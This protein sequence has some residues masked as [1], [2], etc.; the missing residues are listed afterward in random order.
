MSDI[1][2][3]PVPPPP[4]RPLVP[5]PE[6]APFPPTPPVYAP[7]PSAAVAVQ[8]S[9]PKVVGII[10]IVVAALGIMG[11]V[12]GVITWAGMAAFQTNMQSTGQSVQ[13]AMPFITEMGRWKAYTVLAGLVGAGLQIVLLVAAINL[14]RRRPWT[15]GVLR[16]WAGLFI[17]FS[18]AQSVVGYYMQK[19]LYEQI[20][21]K[22]G[23][24]GQF[25]VAIS[26]T[27][28]GASMLFGLLWS[29]ALPVFML[30]WF[31]RDKIK[32]EAA[33]WA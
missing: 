30:I 33:T 4:P 2:R 13:P 7:V 32:A 21:S 14:I 5:P 31:S 11:G 16:I 20:S 12:C 18:L 1:N 22:S 6:P 27:F 3:D 8:S 23:S 29:C 24:Q 19:D 26:H 28:M 9:W 15:I 17:V 25:P 10:A